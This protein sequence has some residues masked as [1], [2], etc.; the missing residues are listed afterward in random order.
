MSRE[1]SR[2]MFG[3]YGVLLPGHMVCTVDAESIS[4][5]LVA[6]GK[7]GFLSMRFWTSTATHDCHSLKVVSIFCGSSPMVRSTK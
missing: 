7:Q 2:S 1:F 6:A 3:L 5:A 4:C